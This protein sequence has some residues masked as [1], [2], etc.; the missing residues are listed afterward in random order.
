MQHKAIIQDLYWSAKR[1]MHEGEWGDDVTVLQ[2]AQ[3][4]E[5]MMADAQKFSADAEITEYQELAHN[6]RSPKDEFEMKREAGRVLAMV[7]EWAESHGF[8]PATSRDV[9]TVATIAN[10]PYAFCGHATITVGDVDHK[11]G[12]YD[13]QPHLDGTG[14]RQVWMISELPQPRS[15]HDSES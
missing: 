15:A 7:K 11:P 4:F 6:L 10:V 13:I 3:S 12:V 1:A 2:R 8:D 14:S 9:C 5:S